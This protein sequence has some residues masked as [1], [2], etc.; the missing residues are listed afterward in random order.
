MK[1]I[2]I[3]QPSTPMQSPGQTHPKMRAFLSSI[4]VCQYPRLL[5]QTLNWMTAMC[6]GMQDMP[7]MRAQNGE[8]LQECTANKQVECQPGTEPLST[9]VNSIDL[10]TASNVVTWPAAGSV[11]IRHGPCQAGPLQLAGD[12]C[13][14]ADSVACAEE[15]PVARLK[16]SGDSCT[17][18][19]VPAG[20]SSLDASA[21]SRAPSQALCRMPAYQCVLHMLGRHSL[22]WGL[23]LLVQKQAYQCTAC[24][25]ILRQVMTSLVHPPAGHANSAYSR[26]LSVSALH[27]AAAGGDNFQDA[28]PRPTRLADLLCS[29]AAADSVQP[30]HNTP[31]AGTVQQDL[32]HLAWRQGSIGSDQ[33]APLVQFLAENSLRTLQKGLALRKRV[34]TTTRPLKQC[35]NS[36]TVARRLL[37]EQSDQLLDEGRPDMNSRYVLSKHDTLKVTVRYH[38]DDIDEFIKLADMIEELFPDVLVEGEAQEAAQGQMDILNASGSLLST[39]SK[40]HDAA[41]IEKTLVD[42][43]YKATR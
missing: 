8:A 21:C 22:E 43:G 30:L 6:N 26:E 16:R 31:A 7:W 33:Q 10:T 28:G 27:P 25:H 35:C 2:Y 18:S 39:L 3:V 37:Q 12:S 17:C 42:A 9:A 19:P 11:L 40:E 24:M 32:L 1:R 23:A 4:R 34:L 36:E 41:A 38:E 14:L 5:G 15:E 13:P 20:G 29:A